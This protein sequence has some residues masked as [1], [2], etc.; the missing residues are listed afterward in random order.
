M[1]RAKQIWEIINESLS[2]KKI[3]AETYSSLTLHNFNN[4]VLH[5]IESVANI[6]PVTLQDAG[7]YSN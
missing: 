1:N 2:I 7:S 5:I 3:P 4:V 6:I